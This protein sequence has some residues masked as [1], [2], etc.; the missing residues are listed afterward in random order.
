MQEN[1]RTILLFGGTFDP[2]HHGHLIL[3]RCLAEHVGAESLVFIPAASPPHKDPAHA[4]G[5]DRL[6]MLRLAVA[7]EAGMEVSPVELGREG[8][9]YTIETVAQMRRQYG[10]DAE[11]AWVIGADS[12]E[13]L[14]T[15][16]REKELVERVRFLTVRRAGHVE[17][18]E[19]ALKALG[20]NFTARQR[21]RLAEDLVETPEIEIS[22]TEIRRRIGEG[23]S[24]RYLLPDPVTDYIHSRG[25]YLSEGKDA[26][27]AAHGGQ[28]PA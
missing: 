28:R 19:E 14:H 16:H 24:V 18:R 8:P 10:P 25:L 11:L 12:L 2:V 9:S 23:L 21:R 6:A 5:P 22:S 17:T 3:G 4:S 15:W 1:P 20:R 26:S 13:Q 7:G 27:P